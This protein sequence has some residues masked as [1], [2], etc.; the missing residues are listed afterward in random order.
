MNDKWIDNKNR[1]KRK[2]FIQQYIQKVE[3]TRIENDIAVENFT[4]LYFAYQ[5]CKINLMVI[6]FVFDFYHCHLY[7]VRFYA[8]CWT[9]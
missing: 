4:T 2:R 1:N 5:S 8:Q 9:S 3:N 7:T 6:V